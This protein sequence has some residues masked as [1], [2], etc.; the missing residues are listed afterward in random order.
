MATNVRLWQFILPGNKMMVSLKNV[1]STVMAILPIAQTVYTLGVIV[2][3]QI[4]EV[5]DAAGY[6]LAAPYLQTC[7]H[8]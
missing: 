7:R 5:C 3:V 1:A 4:I 6:W 8:T 2:L